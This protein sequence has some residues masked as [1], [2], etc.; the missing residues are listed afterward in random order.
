VIEETMT[1]KIYNFVA[2]LDEGIPVAICLQHDLVTQADTLE[3]LP[4]AC[5]YMIARVR[6]WDREEGLDLAAREPPPD[7]AVAAFRNT[8]GSYEIDVDV[9]DED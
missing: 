9:N 3:G 5:H 7:H 8:P 1:V 4:D 6:A 2:C